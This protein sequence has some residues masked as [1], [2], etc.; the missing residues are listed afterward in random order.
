M[1]KIVLRSASLC[2]I[3]AIA[4][5]S[6]AIARKAMSMVNEGALATFADRLGILPFSS[7]PEKGIHDVTLEV[8]PGIDQRVI[9][10]G[11]ICLGSYRPKTFVAPIAERIVANWDVDS[12]LK[13]IAPNAPRATLR[14]KNAVATQRCVLR[15]EY[16]FTCYVTTRLAGDVETLGKDQR[17][18]VTPIEAE[19]VR[20][21]D[22]GIICSDLGE[23]PRGPSAAAVWGIF[24]GGERGA[25][26]VVNREAVVKFIDTARRSIDQT[27]TANR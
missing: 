20:E 11:R 8:S 16:D 17:P 22:Q 15:N 24:N 12:N 23:L 1:N 3:A 26:A 21:I 18:T 19:T 6:P 9:A 5:A 27:D 7:L 4:A 10:G 25:I 14:L 2:L 13:A